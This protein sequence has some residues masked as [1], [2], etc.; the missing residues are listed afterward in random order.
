MPLAISVKELGAI[1]QK[2]IKNVNLD[3]IQHENFDDGASIGDADE[4]R[5]V[6]FGR[7][8]GATTKTE[9]KFVLSQELEK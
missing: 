9:T 7:G 4:P 6:D 2:L 8:L 5:S 1:L 3:K